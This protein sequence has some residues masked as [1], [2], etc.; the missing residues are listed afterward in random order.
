MYSGLGCGLFEGVEVDD[1]HVDGKNPMFGYR[2]TMGRILAA[3]QDSSMHLGMQ[4]FYPAIEHLRKSGELGNVFHGDAGIAQQFG[5]AAGRDQYHAQVGEFAG[6]L[7]QP[8]FIRD[9]EDS[10]LDLTA[11]AGHY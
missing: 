4:S 8:G 6:E 7:D 3:M 2:R 11:V 1:Y 9:T 5:G 10:A